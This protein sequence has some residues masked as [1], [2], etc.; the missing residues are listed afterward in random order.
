MQTF[1]IYIGSNNETGELELERITSI[2]ARQHLAFTVMTAT[3]HWRGTEEETA[4]LVIS[5]EPWRVQV[6]IA[7]L[8]E[9][10]N[11]EAIGYQQSPNIEIA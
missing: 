5:D 1:T 6:T 10:L 9:E 11:Q 2:A 4:V 3:G 8:K 7:A